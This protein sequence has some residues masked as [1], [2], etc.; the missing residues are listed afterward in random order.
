MTDKGGY[1]KLYRALLSDEFWQDEEPFD[2]RSAWIDLLLRANYADNVRI[3]RGQVQKTKRGQ[4]RTSVAELAERWNWS[5]NKVR[6]YLFALKVTKKAQIESTRRG[7][8]ITIEK[9][10][11]FQDRAR[12]DERTDERT[13]GR[14]GERTGS[15]HNKNNKERIK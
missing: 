14:T 8:I 4:I 1:I 5:E 11:F 3:Y 13:D 9:Y 6:R 10:A 2:K 15:R 7:S 12:T